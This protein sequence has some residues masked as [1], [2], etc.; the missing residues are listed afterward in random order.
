MGLG[1]H[2]GG[3]AAA[4]YCAERGAIVTVA[5]LAD[6]HALAESIASFPICR[7]RDSRLA[8]IN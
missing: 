5:D 8:R 1:R 6:E 7:S 2:G 3:V 4:R